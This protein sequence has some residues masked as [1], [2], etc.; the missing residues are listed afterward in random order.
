MVTEIAE[1]RSKLLRRWPRDCINIDIQCQHN[2]ARS[3]IP[4]P[5]QT[6]HKVLGIVVSNKQ[7]T[8]A[9]L[10]FLKGTGDM[11]SWFEPDWKNSFQNSDHGR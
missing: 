9:V 5:K 3:G 6:D 4:A 11:S 8:M 2:P 10:Q 1:K 7:T